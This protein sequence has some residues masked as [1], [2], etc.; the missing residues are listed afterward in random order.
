MT[1]PN[2]ARNCGDVSAGTPGASVLVLTRDGRGCRGRVKSGLGPYL[3]E[4]LVEPV[5]RIEPLTCRLQGGS[6]ASTAVQNE[7][8]IGAG[9]EQVRQAVER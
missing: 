2:A 9:P 5:S 3:N 6:E 4:D 8:L 1:T 7:G